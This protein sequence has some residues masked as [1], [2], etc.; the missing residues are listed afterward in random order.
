MT[1]SCLSNL[2]FSLPEAKLFPA[3]SFTCLIVL[4]IRCKLTFGRNLYIWLPACT[5]SCPPHRP[6]SK[7]PSASGPDRL[8]GSP[9]LTCRMYISCFARRWRQGPC[10]CEMCLPSDDHGIKDDLPRQLHR[11]NSCDL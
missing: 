7:D 3:R 2:G 6:T 4:L 5:K 10:A 8:S 1:P 11:V 9:T